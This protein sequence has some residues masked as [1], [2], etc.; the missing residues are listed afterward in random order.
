MPVTSTLTRVAIPGKGNKVSEKEITAGGSV[1]TGIP[2]EI[3]ERMIGVQAP[4]AIPNG[5]R[6]IKVWSEPGDLHAI[7]STAT[8]LGSHEIEIPETNMKII[9]YFVTWDNMV[10]ALAFVMDKK[11]REVDNEG[12]EPAPSDAGVH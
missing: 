4:G 12:A 10:G 6:V 5:S 9:G 2:D 7:G 8:V 11:I 1:W 3:V